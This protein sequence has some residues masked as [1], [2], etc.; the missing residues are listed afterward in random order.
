M[1]LY[2]ICAK[3]VSPSKTLYLNAV[4][5]RNKNCVQMSNI[6]ILL[7]QNAGKATQTFLYAYTIHI[8]YNNI[9]IQYIILGKSIIQDWQEN[10]AGETQKYLPMQA[11]LQVI[12]QVAL[13]VRMW[14]FLHSSS[15][16]QIFLIFYCPLVMP[17]H[18]W[19][20]NSFTHFHR[21]ESCFLPFI[22]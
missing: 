1:Q 4:V 3:L 6:A 14:Y 20:L 19:L 15:T 2:F 10:T 7:W 9:H 11:V 22:N 17:I 16:I 12:T 5:F 21:I 8:I 18:F 13:P